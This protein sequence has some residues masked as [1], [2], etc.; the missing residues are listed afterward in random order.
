ME[1]RTIKAAVYNRN[2]KIPK[3]ISDATEV[4][5]PDLEY[6]S[7][8]ISGAGMNGEFDLPTLGQFAAATL[9]I[10][11]RSLGDNAIEIS[12]PHTQNLEFRWASQALNETTG[13]VEV[14]DKKVI[15]KGLPKKLGLGKIATNTAE[16][17]A[18]DYEMLAL[19]YISKGV[20]KIE[21]DKLNDVFKVNGID[22]NAAIK[23]VL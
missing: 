1:T 15:F 2:G 12:A 20:V 6:L 14:V 4:T 9:S 17:P 23:N 8:T 13:D 21:I 7:E 5:L 16:E 18:L 3:R 11:A 19:T 22:Y 10:A